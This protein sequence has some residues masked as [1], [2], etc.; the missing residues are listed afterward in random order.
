MIRGHYQRFKD[1]AI[2]RTVA[3]EQLFQLPII[4]PETGRTTPSFLDAGMIDRIGQLPDE[5]FALV[6]RKTTSESIEVDSPY[7]KALR[8][9]AQI[10]RYLR[11]ARALGHDVTKVIY[12]VIKK[13]AIRPRQVTKAEMALA[14][15]A[16]D[17]CGMKLT[18]P[19]PD[20]ETPKMYGARLLADLLARPGFYF[21]R[22]EVARLDGDL[23]EFAQDQWQTQQ[24]IRQAMN[25]CRFFR[26]PAA[27]LEPFNCEYLDVCPELARDPDSIPSGFRRVKRL[28]EELPQP[29]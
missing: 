6:E 16:G 29:A 28:H 21:A 23:E 17:Y 13:P 15:S 20:K 25:A 26:N 11:A 3:V 9:D 2:I 12:D 5:T 22:V 18:G 19:C 8:N 24:D 1:D 7:W 27:C 4:N 14:N 10:S